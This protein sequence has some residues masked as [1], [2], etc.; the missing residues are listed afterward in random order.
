MAKRHVLGRVLKTICLA[1]EKEHDR[2]VR[3]EMVIAESQAER[4]RQIIQRLGRV[5]DPDAEAGKQSFQ[6]VNEFLA[7]RRFGQR[8]FVNLFAQKVV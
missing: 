8:E 6:V 3:A 7:R 2:T 4:N 5:P 1:F